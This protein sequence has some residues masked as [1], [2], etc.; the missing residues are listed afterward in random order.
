MRLLGDDIGMV[1]EEKKERNVESENIA[2]N[3]YVH[4][5]AEYIASC[6]AGSSI[7]AIQYVGKDRGQRRGEF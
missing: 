5:R 1:M 6:A 7:D 3:I 4:A 2:R